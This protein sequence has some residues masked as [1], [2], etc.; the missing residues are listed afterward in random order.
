ME[1]VEAVG[2]KLII[3]KL[4]MEATTYLLNKKAKLCPFFKPSQKWTFNDVSRMTK[5]E[6]KL[7]IVYFFTISRNMFR[8][9]T[10]PS[11]AKQFEKICDNLW[12]RNEMNLCHW[13]SWLTLSELLYYS[14]YYWISRFF[15]VIILTLIVTLWYGSNIRSSIFFIHLL[16]SPLPELFY[17]ILY[18]LDTE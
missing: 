12:S 2:L 8:T 6:V 15:E 10:G 9:Q 1:S 11:S 16:D 5:I 3:L 7:H 18:A 14:I 17:V 4:Y 13:Y